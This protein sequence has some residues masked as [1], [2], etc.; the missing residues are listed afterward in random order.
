MPDSMYY[1]Y[2]ILLL[3][4]PFTRLRIV[5]SS[6]LPRDICRQA[7][8]ALSA[9]ASSYSKLYTL[10]R[11]P[12]FVPYI[13]LTSSITH[14]EIL[15]TAHGDPEK[16]RRGFSDLKSMEDCHNFARRGRDILIFLADHWQINI[17][18]ADGSSHSALQM[19]RNPKNLVRPR[20]SSLNL[21]APTVQSVDTTTRN[22][23]VVDEHR[24]F[25]FCPFPLQ[26]RPLLG[27]GE[28]L[29]KAGFNIL[30]R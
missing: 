21:F 6:F 2:V 7:A 30:K 13:V 10:Q 25:L 3:F 29:E 18:L 19:K 28:I 23:S 17:S 5:G 27:A 12:S 15:G 26:G 11:T 4:R 14:L 22:R 1:H 9:L 24:N 8:D 16:V 20:S